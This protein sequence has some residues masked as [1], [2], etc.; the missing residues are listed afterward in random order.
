MANLKHGIKNM[1]LVLHK[2]AQL[3]AAFIQVWVI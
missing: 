2:G 3:A 1:V